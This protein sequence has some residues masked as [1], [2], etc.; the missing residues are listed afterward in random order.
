MQL[1]LP[2]WLPVQPASYGLGVQS[3]TEGRFAS[4]M[5]C[6]SGGKELPTSAEALV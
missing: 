2:M 3:P 5:F 4:N 1:K 6:A